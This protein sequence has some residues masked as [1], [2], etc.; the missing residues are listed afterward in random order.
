MGGP[1]LWLARETGASVVGVDIS[2]AAVAAATGRAASLGIED[3]HYV[4]GSFAETGLDVASCAGALSCDALQYAPDKAAAFRECARILR[5]RGRL[6]FVAFEFEPRRVAGLPVFGAD[7]VADYAPLLRDA[8]FSLDRYDETPGWRERVE[9][10]YGALLA[11]TTPLHA[12]MGAAAGVLLGE[13][14]LTLQINPYRR[15]VFVSASRGR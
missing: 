11:A 2:A 8:G 3:A 4:W 12:E 13:V 7:P 9:A 5:P 15:R 6:V 10:A 14:A 1:G